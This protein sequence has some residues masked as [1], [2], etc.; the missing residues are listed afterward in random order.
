MRRVKSAPDHGEGWPFL[1]RHMFAVGEHRVD[2][3][4]D[5]GLYKSQVIHFGAS[6]KDEPGAEAHWAGWLAKFE[7]LLLRKLAWISAKVHV[8]TDFRPDLKAVTMPTLIVYGTADSPII[9]VHARRT[10]AAI[11][12]SRLEI[13]DGAPHAVFLTDAQ[14]FNRDLLAFARS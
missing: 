2:G 11:A 9:P 8:E 5:R 4:S 10:H 6:L 13:Y 14:R 12:G 3:D 7:G 1:T